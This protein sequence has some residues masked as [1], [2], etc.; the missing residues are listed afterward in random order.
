MR[1]RTER[2]IVSS[3]AI[4]SVCASA[5]VMETTYGVGFLWAA[6]DMISEM[7]LASAVARDRTCS[8]RL[9]HYV[10]NWS[11]DQLTGLPCV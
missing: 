11:A 10:A 1:L 3:V 7:N 8:L 9:R 5:V 6:V 2:T 4:G